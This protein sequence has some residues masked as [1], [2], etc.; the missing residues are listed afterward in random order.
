MEL[1]L[2][3]EILD[4]YQ[5]LPYKIWFALAEFIDNSIQS[6]RNN[7]ILNEI[8]KNEGKK[9]FVKIDFQN[10][11]NSSPGYITIE[12]NA[13]GMNHQQLQNALTLGKKPDV[14]NGLSKY[15]LGLKTAAFWF[16]RSWCIET[17]EYGSTSKYTVKIDLDEILN[18]EVEFYK[19]Q[20]ANGHN[21]GHFLQ[22][23]PN[24]Q[25]TESKCS[26]EEHGT[27]IHI[28]HL[29]RKF[30]AS[31]VTTCKEY[32]SSIYRRD[33]EKGN[34][35]ILLQ[36]EQLSWSLEDI[37]SKLAMDESG[38]KL[39]RKFSFVI[40]RKNVSGWAGVLLSGGRKYAGFS[41]L[42]ADRVIQG[43]PMAYKPKSIY[44][45]DGGRNDLINQ[46]LIGELNV[47]G[48]E[49]SHTKDQILFDE[50]EEYQL[51]NNLLREIGDL[52]K[53]AASMR[54]QSSREDDY[55][56]INFEIATKYV[57]DNL[58]TSEFKYTLFEKSVLPEEVI[59]SSNEEAISRL[60]KSNHKSFTATIGELEVLIIM[61]DESS[62]YD[63]YLISKA[64]S[65]K[66]KLTIVINKNHTYWGNLDK[67]SAF[68]FLL[69]C[70]YDGIAEWKA[71]FIVDSI[72]PD[73]IKLIKDHFLRLKL[74]FVE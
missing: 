65:D 11:N 19:D 2:G 71:C 43:F 53:A 41:L 46:R 26:E 60:S 32:L 31:T 47:D 40:N 13:W 48:F 18:A 49:V 67:N 35:D 16:G 20:Q 37:K 59:I 66:N 6:Y 55:P 28:T 3:Y 15:G 74:E 27:K 17:S 73:T 57:L 63:P 5:R 21:N 70:I 61:S 12:D 23:K 51:E 42:Q 69:N 50:E 54:V 29:Y 58:K 30:I 9:L 36:G 72:D 62:V 33:L 14:L 45:E 1:L 68:D 4:S 64:R 38:D 34:V 7:P 52:K 25:I 8:Y 39:F 24:L 44:G 10:K 56:Q 22:F